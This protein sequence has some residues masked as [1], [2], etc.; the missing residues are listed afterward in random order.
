MHQH[1][2]TSSRK[3]PRFLKSL[4]NRRFK[5]DIVVVFCALIIPTALIISIFTYHKTVAATMKISNS[6]IEKV[7]QAV[8]EKTTNYLSPAQVLSQI[9]PIVINNPAMEVE[10]GSALEQLFVE[11]VKLQ[12]QIELFYY[13]NERGDFLEAYTTA[14]DDTISSKWI[15]RGVS[16]PQIHFRYRDTEGRVIRETSS[17]DVNFDPRRRPWYQGARETR[18]TYWTDPYVFFAKGEPGITVASPVIDD[19]NTLLGVVAADITLNG[20]STFLRGLDVSANGVVFI[21]DD[22]HRFVAFPDLNRMVKV[23]GGKIT[24]IRATELG[25]KWIA[26]GVRAFEDSGKQ[27][28]TYT[29]GDEQYFARF[30]PF[31]ASFDKNW[32]IAVLLPENDFLGVIHQT[33]K[34]IIAISLSILVLAIIFGLVF[35]RNLSRPIELLTEE[36]RLIRTFDLSSR[37]VVSSYI[38]E[39]QTMADTVAS[40]KNGLRAFRRFVPAELVQQLIASGDEVVPGGKEREITLFFSDIANFTAISEQLPARELMIGLSE[41]FEEM[42]RPISRERGTV[43]KFI[44]DAVMAF[45]GAPLED[46]RQAW[47]ACRAALNCQRALHKLNQRRISQGAPPFNTRIGLHTGFTIVG[48]MGSNE[49]LNYTVLGDNVNLASRL[50]GLNKRYQTGI[51]ISQATYRYVRNQFITR[52]LDLVAVQG[53]SSGVLIYELMGDDESENQAELHQLAT[54][55]QDAFELYLQKEWGSA[56]TLFTTLHETFRTDHP[57]RIYLERCQRLLENDPGPEWSGVVRMNRGDYQS[58]PQTSFESFSNS[59]NAED[60]RDQ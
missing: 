56:L 36:L 33:S 34:T 3:S 40:M 58:P 51:I 47:H 53:K 6:L 5:V 32:T 38:R 13:A 39:I 23:V 8:I 20:L 43:D 12:P 10:L 35:A 15:D 27:Q 57:T 26:E 52:P 9:A 16:P 37:K 49:R 44:G 46:D 1:P 60:I 7:T 2:E 55:F 31:P 4:R 59:G 19:K 25:E 30:T 22:N 17:T 24:P 11:I 45:W 21:L 29:S 28:F 14:G 41:Y 48:N 18:S 42:T 54:T 50:E